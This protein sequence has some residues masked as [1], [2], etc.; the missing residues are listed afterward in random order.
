MVLQGPTRSVQ[1][2]DAPEG[3]GTGFV[4]DDKGHVVSASRTAGKLACL[5]RVEEATELCYS[6]GDCILGQRLLGVSVLAPAMMR[7]PPKWPPG[8]VPPATAAPA[9]GAAAAAMQCKQTLAPLV[10]R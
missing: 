2:V 7:P 1:Q 5:R 9:L 6:S 8:P 4:W 3:N 10:C